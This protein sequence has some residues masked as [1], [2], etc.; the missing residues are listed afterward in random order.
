MAN[1]TEGKQHRWNAEGE[2]CLDCGEKDWFAGPICNGSPSL[3]E[4]VAKAHAPSTP[5]PKPLW[6]E[7]A[8]EQVS[9]KLGIV[10]Q[11]DWD[12]S[13][14]RQKLD[15]TAEGKA[16][17]PLADWGQVRDL[18]VE[19]GMEEE[20]ARKAAGILFPRVT[21]ASV[22]TVRDMQKMLD[23]CSAWSEQ[24]QKRMSRRRHA[25]LNARVPDDLEEIDGIEE[26]ATNIVN[27][28]PL[29]AESQKVLAD[30]RSELYI[31]DEDPPKVDSGAAP[32]HTDLMVAPES[33][34]VY[35]E[36]N[37]PPTT[38]KV[39]EMETCPG[40]FGS[41][42]VS[43]GLH[44][45]ECLKCCG[46]GTVATVKTKSMDKCCDCGTDQPCAMKTDGS[47]WRAD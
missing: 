39:T 36:D 19:N 31:E 30:N 14:M 22:Q 21:L 9:K 29:D 10:H 37:P 32:G 27:G 8:T 18:L 24:E 43:V 5:S 25:A 16:A 33:I 46:W 6:A 28:K 23:E 38:V 7:Y 11:Q 42:T 15:D 35:L 34:D 44:D 1:S 26:L 47:C 4:V 2:R 45:D 40:C 20:H 3:S 41:G 13:I 17:E 12:E